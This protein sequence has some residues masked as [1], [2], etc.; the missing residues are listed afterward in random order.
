MTRISSRP[1]CRYHLASDLSRQES[2]LREEKERKKD[3]PDVSRTVM[4]RE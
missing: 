1:R 2:K 4:L 3:N